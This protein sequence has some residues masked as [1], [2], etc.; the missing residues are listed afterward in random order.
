MSLLHGMGDLAR[1]RLAEDADEL[2]GPALFT[3][4]PEDAAV[5]T[6]NFLLRSRVVVPPRC[7]PS[8][9]LQDEGHDLEIDPAVLQAYS[10]EMWRNL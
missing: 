9:L 10:S 8:T 7:D 5:D 2:V 1:R 3:L 4:L 6:F